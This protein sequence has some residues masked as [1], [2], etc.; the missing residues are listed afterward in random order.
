MT[1]F[2]YG[3]QRESAYTEEEEAFFRS[4]YEGVNSTTGVPHQVED[5]RAEAKA[6]QE[7][8]DANYFSDILY[9]LPRGAAGA[10]ENTLDLIPYVDLP[11][12]LGLGH[13]ETIPGSI[14]EGIT[15]FLSMFLPVTG[16]IG[17]GAKAASTVKG[18]ATLGKVGSK[19]RITK[20]AERAARMQG[21]R[22]AA[23]RIQAGRGLVAGGITDAL[24]WDGNDPRLSNLIQAI[25]G[26]ENGLT[27]FLAAD[28]DDNEQYAGR[29]KN[30]LE[31]AGIGVLAEGLMGIFRLIPRRN[32]A[33][34]EGD[35]KA[36]DAID[37]EITGKAQDIAQQPQTQ[38]EAGELL[39]EQL[40]GPHAPVRQ[41][42]A[43]SIINPEV[44]GVWYRAV[45][46]GD[47]GKLKLTGEGDD[48]LDINPDHGDWLDDWSLAS[49]DDLVIQV[50][51]E[52]KPTAL[53]YDVDEVSGFAKDADL[54]KALRDFQTKYPDAEIVGGRFSDDALEESFVDTSNFIEGRPSDGSAHPVPKMLDGS[55]PKFLYRFMSE[56]E[57]L[58][59]VESGSF[60]VRTQE[61][62]GIDSA[63]VGR[64]H[65]SSEP[66]SKYRS[67]ESSV[68]VRITYS[69]KDE[70]RAKLTSGD[71]VAAI[72]SKSLPAERVER[73]DPDYMPPA[74]SEADASNLKFTKLQSLK[75]ETP[76]LADPDNLH[77]LPSSQGGQFTVRQGKG[78][79]R[80]FTHDD[81]KELLETLKSTGIQG[82]NIRPFL[83][84]LKQAREEGVDPL[85]KI[86]GVQNL[87]TFSEAGVRRLADSIYKVFDF[88]SIIPDKE[89]PLEEMAA[90][91]GREVARYAGYH[92][93]DVI[94]RM[95][96]NA[97][98]IGEAQNKTL[99]QKA[100]LDRY[101]FDT[102]ALAAAVEKGEGFYQGALKLNPEQ[103]AEQFASA[104][105]T[106]GAMV[107]AFALVRRA[108]GRLLG[109]HKINA[110]QL[111]PGRAP[112]ADAVQARGGM[113]NVKK[114]AKKYRTSYRNSRATA[115][116]HAKTFNRQNRFWEMTI[117]WYYGSI[118]SGIR[119][120]STN[121]I[122][123]LATAYWRPMERIFGASGSWARGKFGDPELAK[124]AMMSI[125]DDLRVISILVSQTKMAAGYATRAAAHKVGLFG[126][127]GQMPASLAAS[128]EAGKQRLGVL[129]H[130]PGQ[131]ERSFQK[132]FGTEGVNDLM[133]TSFKEKE[134]WG[135]GI[136]WLGSLVKL[137]T[138]AMQATDEFVK[139]ISYT[140]HVQSKVV[141]QGLE[142]E[143]SG[144]ELDDWVDA[145]MMG[146]LRK[147][148]ATT[149]DNLHREADEI[150]PAT[151]FATGAERQA[152]IDSFIENATKSS[153]IANRSLIAEEGVRIANKVTFQT[154]LRDVPGLISDVAQGVTRITRQHPAT[155]F[156]LPFIK[157]PVNLLTYA[158]DRTPMPLMN[159]NFTQMIGYMGNKVTGLKLK[160]T[161]FGRLDPTDAAIDPLGA[162]KL[163]E[164][165]DLWSRRASGMLGDE[166]KYEA[167]GEMATAIGFGTAFGTLAMSGVITGKGPADLNQRRILEQSGWQANSL[168]IPGTETYISYQRA[169]PLATILAFYADWYDLVKF[170]GPTEAD[171]E[172]IAVAGISAI[173]GN[174]QDK[175][176]LQGLNDLLGLL[177]SPMENI[178]KIAGRVGGSMLIPSIAASLRGV[179]NDYQ[180]EARGVL[181]RIWS[182]APGLSEEV[183]QPYRNILGEPI[184][185]KAFTSA[186]GTKGTGAVE[187]F[188]P[189][190]VNHSTSD[191]LTKH[192]AEL[193]HPFSPPS[194]IKWD[195]DL[196]DFPSE[197]GK[198]TA[199]DRYQELVGKVKFRGRTLRTA[200]TRLINSEGYNNLPEGV[201]DLNIE[202]PQV[203]MI[204]KVINRYRRGAAAELLWEFPTLNEIVQKRLITNAAHSQGRN[205]DAVAASMNIQPPK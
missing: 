21:R 33:V 124:A 77:G 27:E 148:Q 144:K 147:N 19:L 75:K 108:S 28:P 87:A 95:I 22:G 133:G 105:E 204:D 50:D 169:D 191:A 43:D 179:T 17:M 149:I 182:R 167:L 40:Q 99:A 2:N 168:K 66:R 178:Q 110:S 135:L 42:D 55:T 138:R 109:A 184:S 69:A 68:L 130:G 94:P 57:Y 59:G 6:A 65:A 48:I 111:K 180:L 143:L 194:N 23:W 126:D 34:A 78:Y 173:A 159:R 107:E 190:A 192:F 140:S 90:N 127:P 186:L 80:S 15:S 92:H 62:P 83:E 7:E 142:A 202:S 103:A 84:A 163:K 67:N 160:S 151:E 136:N 71:E 74:K 73:M 54:V 44:E 158:L 47:D 198:R 166:Q 188:L 115:A 46:V 31:G 10:V 51:S 18:A 72:S 93:K 199:H 131:L 61:G 4:R 11:E 200:L 117:D 12:N 119:T 164:V 176:Y 1:N 112:L 96:R 76:A 14:L 193:G 24:V 141:R 171:A 35:T 26:L 113:D 132:G 89:M 137:P 82:E 100:Y 201:P 30:V 157:T 172:D 114:L 195:Q 122:G 91:A 139:H 118:L 205:P 123:A 79:T 20:S 70:W 183:L 175:S 81:S 98:N 134:G 101:L 52:G 63:G 165:N 104:L 121:G 13:S 32:K 25:P 150:F 196:R 153:H 41:A 189:I 116:L 161:K 181:D 203:K 56:E 174:L 102:D 88:A 170:S 85:H 8:S 197:D 60:K 156:F 53:F 38:H 64:H 37:D 3:P 177:T 145:E 128:M 125:Q 106:A 129:T 36:V 152:A 155:V 49:K 29:L 39:R 154:P 185:K 97:N 9:A 120:L 5:E 86:A 162:T 187:F 45:T 16:A 58:A 146:F